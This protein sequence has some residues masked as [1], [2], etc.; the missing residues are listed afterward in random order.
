MMA[1]FG[2]VIAVMLA[3]TAAAACGDNLAAG[4]ADD[5][6]PPEMVLD[7]TIEIDGLDAPVD[8]FLDGAGVLHLAC[9]SDVDCFAA[10]GYFHAAHRFFQMDLRRRL[11]RGRLSEAAGVLAL[12]IDVGQRLKHATRDGQPIEQRIW[13]M[14]SDDTRAAI[15]AYTRGVNSWIA[16]LRAGDHDARDADERQYPVLDSDVLDDWDPLDSVASILLLADTLTDSSAD[17]I[18]LGEIATQ[19][20]PEAFADIFSLRPTSDSTIVPPP[21]PLTTAAAAARGRVSSEHRALLRRAAPL[22]RRALTG[23][24]PSGLDPGSLGS[25]NWVVGP[26]RG[27]GQVLLSN[28]THLDMSNPSV[29]YLVHIDSKTDGDGTV[30]AAGLSFPGLP[31]IIIGRN[32]EIAWGVTNTSGDF[33]DVYVETVVDG[34][35]AVE[36]NGQ[37]VPFAT[38]DETFEIAG[39]DPVTRTLRYVPHH[40]PVIE[41]PDL[42]ANRALSVRWTLNEADTDLEFILGMMRASSVTEARTALENVT[43]AGQNF[44]VIDRDGNFGWF[45]YNRWAR[46]PWAAQFPPFLP[47]PG[48]GEAEWGEPIPYAELP[49][50]FNPSTGF[51][52]T[53][54]NDFTGTLADGDPVDDG[55]DVLQWAVASGL[56]HER[57]ADL[58]AARSDHDLG[59]MREIQGDVH[60]LL[61]EMTV[62]AILA[63]VDGATLTER[64]QTVVATLAAWD[65]ECPTGLSGT[66]PDSAPAAD[67][68]VVASAAGCAAFHVLWPR[69][70]INI[71]DDELVA[72]GVDRRPASNTTVFA[73]T[74]TDPF[75]GRD[76]F[77]NVATGAVT[78][79]KAE[80]VALSLD[81]AAANLNTLFGPEPSSWLWGRIHQL[82]L[83]ADL[84]AQFGV[85][86]FD[87]PSYARDGGLETVNVGTPRDG[88]RGQFDMEHGSSFRFSCA[89]SREQPLECTIQL[90]GGQ[91][92]HRDNPLFLSLFGPYLVNRP[93]PFVFSIADAIAERVRAYQLVAE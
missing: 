25:N 41:G 89:G 24:R 72:A 64:A 76:Y 63:A 53:A 33:V 13:D 84:F 48:T 32:E 86:D 46:K 60:S 19:L 42:V 92:H 43:T 5:A 91:V 93:R 61:G 68:A 17:E 66:D 45:P 70:Q 29:F 11:A 69:L 58:L 14:S 21:T 57:I 73:L 51:I 22:L 8:V 54:N 28:D 39:A 38:R 2:S 78:E 30:H 52:A 16:D 36:F 59:S 79:T 80:I 49:Q 55:T 26:S 87:S 81:L 34:G 4:P 10:Q 50:L 9:Q 35:A 18:E 47:L 40:G 27:G 20:T 15:E 67:P 75:D 62:P 37:S 31:G 3:A 88:R 7:D 44:V 74:G 65:F 12:D 23:D 83:R 82:R 6:G 90:P 85:S 71:F 56:R 77:D 1:R